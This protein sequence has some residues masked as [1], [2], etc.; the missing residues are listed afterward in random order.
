MIH[1]H[2]DSMRTRDAGEQPREK[3]L[4]QGSRN[5]TEAELLAIL[6]GTGSKQES[7]V[8][9]SRRMLE[10]YQYDL[11]AMGRLRPEDL[12][13]FHGMG[14]AKSIAVVAALELGRRHRIQ[15][16]PVKSPIQSSRAVFEIFQP[17]LAAL[18]HEEFWVL[19]LSRSNAVIS[20]EMIS[21]G[22][23]SGT[24]VDPKIIF[25][26]ALLKRASSI[27]LVHNHPSGNLKPSA[28]DQSIT[29]KVRQA[30]DY[31][32]I[33]VLDHLIVSEAGYFSFAD[34]SLL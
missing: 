14:P 17:L 22:G 16:S 18:D 5:L 6:I 12:L 9:L 19:L 28:A 13:S 4:L 31:L 33:P 8:A 32:D 30:G 15:S 7:A 23:F 34:E 27:I 24:V 10:A 21:K 26:I 25:N 20:R 29:K 1:D 11:H 3:L 2:G